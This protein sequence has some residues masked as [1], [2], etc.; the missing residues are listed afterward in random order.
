MKKLVAASTT[1]YLRL[2]VATVTVFI[3]PNAFVLLS[4]KQT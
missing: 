1:R 4:D 2:P 3:F